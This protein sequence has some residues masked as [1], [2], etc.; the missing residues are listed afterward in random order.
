MKYKCIKRS[1]NHI[2]P[3]YLGM[4]CLQMSKVK[5]VKP[6]MKQAFLYG[7]KGQCTNGM[8]KEIDNK[9]RWFSRIYC[10]K[11][12]TIDSRQPAIFHIEWSSSKYGDECVGLAS[13]LYIL[14]KTTV[15]KT[16]DNVYSNI[17]TV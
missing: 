4:L 13:K 6:S 7:I 12:N 2:I 8:A 17:F 1:H 14:Q 11:C 9:Y 16:R 3:T 15:K 5:A 10:K